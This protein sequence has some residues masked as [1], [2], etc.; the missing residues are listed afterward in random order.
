MS[1]PETEALIDKLTHDLQPVGRLRAPAVRA[2]VWLGLVGGL[3]LIMALFADDAALARR[4]AAAPDMWLSVAGAVLTTIAACVAAFQLT[5]PDRSAR[6]ALLPL[7][8]MLWWV[9]ASGAG[10]LRTLAAGENGAIRH[11]FDCLVF[12]VLV[13]APLSVLL[14]VMLRRGYAL[15]PGLVALM[16][17]LA[18]AAASATLLNFFH[19]FDAVA[20]DLLVHVVAVGLVIGLNWMFGERLLGQHGAMS[21]NRPQT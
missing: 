7:P 3:G 1:H 13:S 16:G 6:W 10:C 11:S 2:F 4:M 17:G 20:T 18:T 14:I 5:L 21:P 19:P 9:G 12:V 15:R 8:A